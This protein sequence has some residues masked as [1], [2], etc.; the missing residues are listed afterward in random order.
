[1]FLI[2]AARPVSTLLAAASANLVVRDGFA[3][4]F[5][6]PFLPLDKL[7]EIVEGIQGMGYTFVSPEAALP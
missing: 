3:S 1:L 4:F 6:H 7:K 5:F 2:Y